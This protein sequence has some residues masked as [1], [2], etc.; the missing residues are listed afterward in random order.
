MPRHS[1]ARYCVELLAMANKVSQSLKLLV[2]GKKAT[3]YLKYV[4][5]GLH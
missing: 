3:A 5:G 2:L 1:H 4:L